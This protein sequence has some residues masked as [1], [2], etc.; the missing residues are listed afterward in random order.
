MKAVSGAAFA[1]VVAAAASSACCWLPLAAMSL[2]LGIGGMGGMF[3]RHRWA[4]L[5][6]SGLLL[7]LG[8]LLNERVTANCSPDGTCP[9]SPARRRTFNRIMLAACAV[10]ADPG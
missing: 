2:G 6:A 5:G 3:E 1:S 8:W 7:A 9:P 10:G 4:L